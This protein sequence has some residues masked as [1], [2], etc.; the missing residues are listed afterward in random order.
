MHADRQIDRERD[1]E[2]QTSESACD[3][4]WEAEEEEE[5]GR[6]VA[7]LDLVFSYTFFYNV[8]VERIYA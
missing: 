1:A 3:K 8:T 4:H 5:T 6:R 2:I 7:S